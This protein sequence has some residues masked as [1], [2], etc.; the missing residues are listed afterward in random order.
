MTALARGACWGFLF[1]LLALDAVSGHSASSLPASAPV[2]EAL[3]RVSV[4]DLLPPPNDP[5]YSTLIGDLPQEWPAHTLSALEAWSLYP[6]SY[7]AAETRP[8]DGPIVAVIDSGIDPYHPDFTNP[9]ATGP[10]VSQ[11]GQLLLSLARS[12]V[13]GAPDPHDVTDELGRGTHLAGLIAAAANN[14]DTAGSGIAGLAYSARLLPLKVTNATGSATWGDVA[15]AITYAADQGAAVILIGPSGPTWSAQLQAAVDYAWTRGCFLV[16]PIGDGTPSFAGS[17]PHVFGVGAVTAAGAAADYSPAGEGVALLAPGGDNSLGV[18][19]T[20]PTYACPFRPDLSGPPYGY[21]YGTAYAAAHVAAAAALHAGAA[22]LQ[23]DAGDEGATIWQALQRSAS[24]PWTATRGYGPLSLAPL[25]EGT[26]SPQTTGSL[27]G[28]VTLDGAP[29]LEA[30]VIATPAAGD[31]AFVT[32]SSWPAGAYRLAN[33]P[34]GRYTVTASSG[35]KTGMWE[36]LEVAAGC[37]APGMDF[38]LDGGSYDAALVSADLPAAAVRGRSF[39]LTDTLRNTGPTAWTRADSIYLTAEGAGWGG[40]AGLRPDDIVSP[41]ATHSFTLSPLAPEACGFYPLSLRMRQQGGI[42]DFGETA[43]ATLSITSFLDVPADHWALAQIEA[44]KA[45][46]IVSGYPG[47]LY[48][49]GLVVTRDQMAV[50]VSRALA[51]GDAS[52]PAGPA[53]PSFAD[54][55]TEHWAYRYIEY[56]HTRGVV[57]GYWDGYHPSA[58]LDRGQMAVFMA[59]AMAGGEAGLEDYTPPETPTFPDVPADFWSFRHVEYLSQAG[60]VGGYWDGL[61]HPERLCTRDQM[62]VY[63]A[64]GFGLPM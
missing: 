50:F 28:R 11:G 22:N 38:L 40:Q 59:R 23:P 35:G 8:A 30:Q 41:G 26:A 44:V 27:I 19:S 2:A 17:C 29:V 51:G 52:V 37:D 55:P 64:R 6:G 48:R 49:P 25:L 47:D 14:G 53:T 46:G 5:A 24:E 21:R 58:A 15:N 62:A 34:A 43:E 10:D 56:A 1:C 9:G 54:V 13:S 45:A 32:T 4:C 36:R 18:Y 42:G 7:F 39:A 33:L 63:V 31:D 60:V 61:Y 20:L 16:A 3:A 12:F 57:G